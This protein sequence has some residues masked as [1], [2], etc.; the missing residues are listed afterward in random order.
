MNE[1]LTRPVDL[2]SLSTMLESMA[3]QDGVIEV[4]CERHGSRVS[5]VSIRIVPGADRPPIVP[6][7]REMEREQIARAL[8]ATSGR[9]AA[10]ARM[11]GI[12]ERNLYRK[13]RTHHI[14]G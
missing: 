3:V 6:T 4:R 14:E 10:A 7:L 2:A 13:I 1:V 8:A 11:L 9:R 12:S 5:I